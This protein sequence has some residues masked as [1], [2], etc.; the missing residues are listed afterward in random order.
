MMDDQEFQESRFDMNRRSADQAIETLAHS[1]K[2]IR[3][4]MG[5][6]KQG[7][8]KLTEVMTRM[9]VA[10]ESQAR[11]RRD[12]LD[13]KAETIKTME[14]IVD[15]LDKTDGR[16][17]AL[18]RAAPTNALTSGWIL[19]GAKALAVLVGVIVLSKSGLM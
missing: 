5:E 19:E 14:K 17:D 18:E 1:V 10:E 12:F 8:A 9:A 2:Y 16:V 3:E 13:S 15:R 4:D 11:D 7:M 6:L